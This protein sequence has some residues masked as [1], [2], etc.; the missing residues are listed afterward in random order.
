VVVL[1]AFVLLVLLVGLLDRSQID[2]VGRVERDT[3][4][5]LLDGVVHGGLEVALEDHEVCGRDLGGL[6]DVELEVV[7]LLAGL[8]E[9]LHV[10]MVPGDAVGGKRQRVERGRDRHP[11]VTAGAALVE[12]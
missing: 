3:L 9:Q 8:G 4:V 6:V 12:G 5:V 11:V 1:L 10:G 7:R 2:D